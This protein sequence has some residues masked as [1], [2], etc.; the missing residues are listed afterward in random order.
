MQVLA[1][2]GGRF[3]ELLADALRGRERW[4]KN[5]CDE[6]RISRAISMQNRYSVQSKFPI[7]RKK[8]DVDPKSNA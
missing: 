7:L 4:R 1:P 2:G 3:Q 5:I 8:L 6:R